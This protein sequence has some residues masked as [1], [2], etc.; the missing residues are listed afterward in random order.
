MTSV[1]SHHSA[2]TATA[3]VCLKDAIHRLKHED[4]TLKV[5]SLD[6]SKFNNRN[7]FLSFRKALKKSHYLQELVLRNNGM[8]SWKEENRCKFIDSIAACPSLKRLSITL[9]NLNAETVRY[10]C[11]A[12]QNRSLSGLPSLSS[13]CLSSNRMGAEGARFLAEFLSREN[14]IESLEV[15]DNEICNEGAISLGNCL[16]NNTHLK[17][18]T[19]RRNSIEGDGLRVLARSLAHCK[20]EELLLDFNAIS[21]TGAT[22]LGEALEGNPRLR[23]LHLAMNNIGPSGGANLASCLFHNSTLRDL[24]LSFDNPIQRAT[25]ARMTRALSSVNGNKT[26]ERLSLPNRYRVHAERLQFYVQANRLGRRYMHDDVFPSSLW[27]KILAEASHDTSLLFFFL[28]GKPDLMLR[29]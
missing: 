14:S 15:D 6:G 7:D 4:S 28:Q 9:N 17:R 18:L 29:S 26:L 19:L 2:S 16:Q 23:V 27:P 3:T 22:A 20:L 1:D 12:L 25:V 10:L 13:L 11:Q 24:D 5:L 21:D 8:E